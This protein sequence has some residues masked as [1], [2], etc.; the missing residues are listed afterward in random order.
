[1]QITA[2]QAIDA[3]AQNICNL[4][5]DRQTELYSTFNMV[6]LLTALAPL[7]RPVLWVQAP[8]PGRLGL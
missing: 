7:V 5:K 1:M 6:K 4:Y 2:Q 8:S 3:Y